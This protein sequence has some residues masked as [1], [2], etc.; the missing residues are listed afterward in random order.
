M[1]HEQQHIVYS[2]D[3]SLTPI[4]NFEEGEHRFLSNFYKSPILALGMQFD[5]VEHLYQAMKAV[6]LRPAMFVNGSYLKADERADD[7]VRIVHESHGPGIAKKLGR[8]ISCRK[9][10]ERVKID[11]M[12]FCLALKFQDPSLRSALLATG[13]RQL[14][15]GNHWGDV[16][17]GVCK[18][19]GSNYLGI[20]LM[21]LRHN[22]QQMPVGTFPQT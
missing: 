22:L 19:V 14:I 17:W 8:N 20:L 6:S 9:D 7:G 11:V 18:G 10:W 12:R 16:F 3:A 21:E 15:E 13:K 2:F 4:D 1:Q 5:T